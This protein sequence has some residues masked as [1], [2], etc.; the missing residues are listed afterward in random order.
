MQAMC[1]LNIRSS[2]VARSALVAVCEVI[3]LRN[4]ERK[5]IACRAHGPADAARYG[6][7]DIRVSFRTDVLGEWQRGLLQ[8]C[9]GQ[10]AVGAALPWDTGGAAWRGV[11][12][13]AR[14][15]AGAHCIAPARR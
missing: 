5:G 12:R 7:P 11:A 15:G 1:V 13:V 4:G 8:L 3:T 6:D 14:R 10:H 2:V 9:A